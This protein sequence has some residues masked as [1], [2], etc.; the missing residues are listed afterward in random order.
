MTTATAAPAKPSTPPAPPVAL[1]SVIES[2][3]RDQQ[4]DRRRYAQLMMKQQ[5]S[6]GEAKE[7]RRII[8]AL[9]KTPAD[10]AADQ[11]LA[12]QFN[13]HRDMV[14]RACGLGEKISAANAAVQEHYELMQ[15]EQ[16]KLRAN[17]NQLNYAVEQLDHQYRNGR[18][19]LQQLQKIKSGRPDLFGEL[20]LPPLTD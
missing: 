3:G 16:E 2:A 18:D 10:L 6:D 12:E 7:L 4:S 5:L 1:R 14:G 17:H 20:E 9:G 8:D 15:R 13:M 11:R 19:A